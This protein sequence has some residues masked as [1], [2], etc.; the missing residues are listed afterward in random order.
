MKTAEIE[1]F[2]A[3][4]ETGS[5]ARAS[6]RL[7]VTQ[8]TVTVRLRSLERELGRQLFVRGRGG[9]TLTSVGRRFEHTARI[10]TGLWRQARH[11]ASMPSSVARIVNIAF[12][13]DLWSGFGDR[14]SVRLQRDQPD[15]AVS[16]WNGSREELKRWVQE[17]AVDAAFG[18]EPYAVGSEARK[19]ATDRLHVY[20]DVPDASASHHPGYIYVDLGEPFREAH[21]RLYADAATA[22]SHFGCATWA[23]DHILAVG[24]S[25]YL[26][27]RLAHPHVERGRLFRIHAAPQLARPIYLLGGGK[28]G[29]RDRLAEVSSALLLDPSEPV[30]ERMEEWRTRQDSNL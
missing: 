7:N 11:E 12:E 21:A 4:V 19:I 27:E 18:F 14:L 23:L 2:L 17:G 8:S 20:S 3:I 13:T 30:P 16:V 6:A 10:M 22:R 28:S 29:L 24:G 26:P 9:A 15:L 1:T 25:A 5:L